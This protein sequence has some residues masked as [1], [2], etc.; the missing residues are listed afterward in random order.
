MHLQVKATEHISFAS[1]F[2]NAYLGDSNGMP[3]KD[4]EPAVHADLIAGATN[5]APE[6]E[7]DVS[8][9]RRSSQELAVLVM[10]RVLETGDD[11]ILQ[12]TRYK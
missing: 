5:L 8:L 10:P 7:Q 9:Q 6:E 11:Q 12:G 2:K 1:H 3:R 4:N